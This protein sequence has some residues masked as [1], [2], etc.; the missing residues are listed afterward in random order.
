MRKASILL[1]MLVLLGLPA[2]SLAQVWEVEAARVRIDHDPPRWLNL[3]A[4]QIPDGLGIHLRRSVWRKDFFLGL[5]ITHGSEEVKVEACG[6]SDPKAC[7]EFVRY[8]GGASLLTLGWL[9][10]VGLTPLMA[11]TVRPELGIGRARGT[12]AREPKFETTKD[13]Q[14]AV[15]LGFSAGA[16]VRLGE[17]SPFSVLVSGALGQ[18]RPVLRI[19]CDDCIQFFTKPLPQYSLSVGFRWEAR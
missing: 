7:G 13:S 17:E 10:R 6:L 2:A 11:A 15:K 16:A 9:G 1:V 4:E 3:G 5:E 18:L 14:F 8:S 12:R 19:A